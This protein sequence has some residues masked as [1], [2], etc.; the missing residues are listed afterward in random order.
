VTE[1][2]PT[3]PDGA[4][5]G[6]RAGPASD[7]PVAVA[8]APTRGPDWRRVTIGFAL[9]VAGVVWLLDVSDV[10]DLRWRVVLPAALVGVGVTLVAFPRRRSVGPLVASGVVLTVVVV[11]SSLLPA[12]IGA[13]VGD[14]S[15]RP[16]TLD[17][18]RSSYALGIGALTVD[19]RALSF[20]S[21]TE[22]EVSVGIG[23]LV[24]LVPA[25][26]S[27]EI[28]ARVGVG[29]VL[30]LDRSRSGLGV[31]LEERVGGPGAPTLSLELSAGIGKIEVAR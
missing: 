30:V 19:L 3:R 8:P 15:E 7:E 17:D 11:A 16:A 31:R 13:G 14:R 1:Q 22:V 18:L 10:V 29:E 20:E 28:V 12:P 27:F 26:V 6:P 25:G 21:D 24:V 9:V 2:P 23:E 4:E 5:H